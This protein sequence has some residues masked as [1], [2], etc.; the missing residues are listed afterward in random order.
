MQK[1][2]IVM[3]VALAT[4]AFVASDLAAARRLGGGG[5]LGMQR[6]SVAPRPPAAAPGA[7]AQPVMPAQP[8]AALPGKAAAAATP[9]ASG[10]S[11]WMGPIAGIAAGLGLAALLSHFGLPEGLGSFLLLALL[12]IAGIAV[13]RMLMSRRAGPRPAMQYAGATEPSLTPG[14]RA[15]PAP[16]WGGAPRREPV[17]PAGDPASPASG[18]A[19]RPFPP[20]FD[21]EGFARQAKIQYNRLQAAYDAGDRTLMAEVMTPEMF[22]EVCRELASRGE[23]KPTEVVSLDAGVLEVTTE[24]ASHWASV[25]YTGLVREDG[26]ANPKAV[27]EVWNLTKPVD[28]SSGWLLAGI[29]QTA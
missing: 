28:G 5:G 26:E 7:A 10:M 15:E 29:Q 6:Q 22:A 19:A 20:G 24:G 25:R 14:Y 3:V 16:A 13:V 27:D 23:H 18:P 4:A 2:G 17:M 1:L 12:V 21:A 9:A 11:R 8:G